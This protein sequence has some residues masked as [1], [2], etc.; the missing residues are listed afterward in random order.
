MPLL[1]A[2]RRRV[3][4]VPE[5][6]CDKRLFDDRAFKIAMWEFKRHLR[7]RKMEGFDF[8]VREARIL[9]RRDPLSY[10]LGGH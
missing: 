7:D 10:C 2:L 8:S 1:S 4:S 5:V 9:H 6:A 3:L